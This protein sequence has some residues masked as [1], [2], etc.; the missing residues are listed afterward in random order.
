MTEKE[1]KK[2]KEQIL[3]FMKEPGYVP[4]RKRDIAALFRVPAEARDELAYILELLLQDGSI[5]MDTRGRYHVEDALVLQGEFR[6]TSREFGFLSPEDGSGDIY[7]E[8][9]STLGALNGDIVQAV[10]FEE[11]GKYAGKSRVGRVVKIVKRANEYVV[12]TFF[13]K[14]DYGFVVAEDKRLGSDIFIDSRYTKGAVS[15][16]KVA[17]QITD[18]GNGKQNP[19][20]K[21]VEILGHINDPGSDIVTVLRAFGIPETFPE[22]VM[23]ATETV[24]ESITE[25]ECAGRLDLRDEVM[26]TIDGEDAK[27]LDDAVSLRK[28]KNGYVL[29]VHIADVTEYV[30]EGSALDN[31]AKKRGTSVYLINRVVPML[32]HRLSNGI[33]SLNEGEDRLALSCIMDLTEDGTIVGH[34]LAESVIH[35]NR[36]TSYTEVNGILSAEDEKKPEFEKEYGEIYPML[37]MMAEVSK[38]LREKRKARGAID[39]DFPESKIILDESGRPAEIKPYERNDAT[40]MIEDFM[41]AANETVAE[42]FFWQ[43]IPFVYRVHESPDEEKIKRLG[44]LI[45]NF[46]YNLRGSKTAPHPKVLQALLEKSDGS[47]EEALIA[48]LTLR[49]MKQAKYMVDCEGHFGLATKYYCHFTSPIRRYPDLQIH[50]IIKENLRGGL[51]E[52]R[53][54]HYSCILPEVAQH[55]SKTERTAEEA[56]RE[57]LKMKKCEYAEEHL[58]EEAEGIISGITNYGMYVELPNTVEGMIR[59]ADITDDYYRFDEEN[60][61]LV[62]ERSYREFQLGQTVKIMIHR[63]DK[64]LKTIDFLLVSR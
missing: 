20:G 52:R 6:G 41:L 22:E 1:L 35:V 23:Q 25:K 16:H 5:T 53:R 10:I 14:K 49:S 48:R 15:G 11:T 47:P 62:G 30:K 55:S 36:R 61:R 29:G 64:L 13:K 59:L 12:G 3:K 38:L 19:M 39:F 4:M 50:R 45:Q 33:C 58:G 2:R 17:V 63:V 60:Y 54:A 24:P 40:R 32:P 42:D 43:E 56:E 21:I 26:I 57:L 8:G 31:E 34:R 44:I 9:G 37:L 7:I 51:D 18:F 46:G 27:D 28:T